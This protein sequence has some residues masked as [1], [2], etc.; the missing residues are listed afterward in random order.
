[1]RSV[2]AVQPPQRGVGPLGLAEM[3]RWAGPDQ[4][5]YGTYGGMSMTRKA[6]A[7][8]LVTMYGNTDCG[9]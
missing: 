7:G 2:K 6:P 5:V 8:V 1:M 3:W 4:Q 9:G